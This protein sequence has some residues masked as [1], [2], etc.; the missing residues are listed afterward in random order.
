[1]AGETR[2]KGSGV[3]KV[4]YYGLCPNCGGVITSDRL[5]EGLPC[6]EC[7]PEPPTRRDLRSILEALNRLN[8]LKALR[9]VYELLRKYDDFAEFF[10]K[11]TGARMWGAQRFWARRF[12]KGKSFAVIAPT[13][14][15]KTTFG[16]V[17]ALYTAS[18][19]GRVLMVF[20]TSTLAYQ[21]YK[22]ALSYSSSLG[23]NLRIVTYNSLLTPKER[24]EAY[25]TIESGAFDVVIVT[26]AF[27]PKGMEALGKYKFNLIFV[28]DV[29]SVMKASSR[30]IERLLLLLG[31]PQEA[32]TKALEAAKVQDP[33]ERARKLGELEALLKGKEVGSLIVS[34]MLTR[35]RRTAR[36]ALF[37]EI[38]GFEVG[39]RSEGLR[40]VYDLYIRP[41]GDIKATVLEVVKRLGSGGIIY[42]PTD[43]GKEFAEELYSYLTSNG[44]K[45]GLYLTPKRRL[46][47][48]FEAGELE[49]LIG[50]ATSRSALV[51]GIDLPHRIRY[52]VFAGVPKI[53]FRLAIS[54]FTPGRYI[55]LLAS[56]RLIAPSQYKARID[57]V[58]NGLRNI[59]GVGSDRL[60][61]ILKAANEGKPLEGFDRYVAEV[62]KEAISLASELLSLREVKEAMGKSIVN[63]YQVGSDIYVVLPDSPAYIQGSGRTSRMYLGGISHGISVLI[64]DNEAVFN[65][66]SRDLK[67]RLM[68]FQF[69]EYEKFNI[70]E[71]LRVIDSERELIRS[72][73]SGNV[74]PNIAQIDP[75]KSAL[76]IV[77]SPTKARTIAGFFGRPS[78][79]IIGNVKVYEVTSG[80]LLLNIVAT[81][82][83]VV[84]L[85]AEQYGERVISGKSIEYV[86][87]HVAGSAKDY[88][89]VLKLDGEFAPIYTDIRRC[90]KCGRTFNEDIQ[91]CPFDN[92]PLVS[93]IGT[94]N[95][96]RDLASEVD[97]VLIGTD[98]DSEGEK[99]AWDVYNLLRQ[100]VNDIRRI[101]FHEVTKK[102]ILNALENARDINLNMVKAQLVRRIED[103]WIGFG[104]SLYLQNIFNERNLSAGRVQ[105][106]VLKWIIDRYLEYRRNKVIRLTV[107]KKVN[108]EAIELHFDKAADNNN[109]KAIRA[110]LRALIKDKGRLKIKVAVV[111]DSYEEVNPPP[112]FTT[113]SMLAEAAARLRMSAEEA[114]RIAQDLFET[115]LITY[116]RTDSTRVSAVGISIAR[117]Y[118]EDKL[119]GGLFTPRDWAMGELGA[120]EC[121]RPTR[122]ID[123][124]ELRSLIASGVL[125]VKLTNRHLALYDLIF[126]RFIASQ[127]KQ[128]VVRKRR[129]K[130][131]LM[132]DG[133][134]VAEGEEE[135]VVEV[136]EAGFL[137]AYSTV[138]PSKPLPEG[139]LTLTDEDEAY[140]K[141]IPTTYPYNEG[142]VVAEMKRRGIGRPSTYARIIETLRRRGYVKSMGKSHILIPTKWALEIYS[143]LSRDSKLVE[144]YLSTRRNKDV[145]RGEF[146]GVL[147]R[148]QRCF[149]S[150][151]SEE[152]TRLVERLMDLVESGDEDYTA[153]LQNLFDEALKYGILS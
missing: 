84:E 124:E 27:L 94:I 92:T 26:N 99:I 105:T 83:H 134:P 5:N 30:N 37:R 80:N 69:V 100:Y 93:S 114:M 125:K 38:L 76:V 57:K 71:A 118:I 120:H 20:P 52:V 126:R 95:I 41:R 149:S 16:I 146:E 61:E 112:P 3:P 24:A 65:S 15:G 43:L 32:I 64:V 31:V 34:G 151:I 6:H 29:D 148:C 55:M 28:D 9:G 141:T 85:A 66:L 115:G 56:L 82:G 54:E 59:L 13:G 102:A 60:G 18:K 50:L 22:K 153:V 117:E 21:V 81:K 104:L 75:L 45:A 140:V 42:V 138:K 109:A 96:L 88:Y 79:R 49:V 14:S 23:L 36:A 143:C 87:R 130:I 25:E 103:R 131:I 12:L 132:A 53:R 89:Y 91:R 40:N 136:K 78:V 17:A 33:E 121:I 106:P 63:I 139:E 67:Y 129:Y 137:K 152:R 19:G 51:R 142:E 97:L 7:L 48:G 113:D 111:N 90:P 135:Y 108:G 10:T 123:V 72:I 86:K 11:A 73:M 122:P 35:V 119:G 77:E 47:E 150:L 145:E 133:T 107:V 8:R 74:P 127:M 128:A 39:G 110:Q 70:G 68:D 101:E 4:V 1:M 62:A 46:L 116:H 58:L 98:P 44:V 147:N 2:S 144:N